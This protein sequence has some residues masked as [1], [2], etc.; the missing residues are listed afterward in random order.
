MPRIPNK[1]LDSTFFLY[2]SKEDAEKGSNY[3]GS[4]FIISMPSEAWGS[5]ITYFYGVTNWH[6]AVSGRCYF[7]R[8]NTCDGYTEIFEYD[9]IDWVFDESGDDLAIILLDLD[10]DKHTIAPIPIDLI[11]KKDVLLSPEE[12]NIGLGDDVFMLGRFVDSDSKK[13]NQ[14]TA[15]FG[16]ISAM[17]SPVYNPAIKRSNESYFLDMHSRS[18]YSGSPVFA[19]RTPGTNLEYILEHLK[20]S[21]QD[22]KFLLLGIHWGQ[23]KETMPIKG[24]ENEH[25]IGMSGMTMAIPSWKILD[26]LQA[27]KLVK[28]RRIADEKWGRIFEEEG[29][30]P[31]RAVPE[32]SVKEDDS[33]QKED[34]HNRGQVPNH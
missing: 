6:V 13:N 2:S 11:Y 28:Q 4:G 25:V 15:R 3:G 33:S 9:S 32:L 34:F 17:P 18:G 14:P 31:G 10:S 21:L 29:R 20:P 1:L 26:L 12:L 8:V 16:H 30:Y 19:Y 5:E 7:V 27:E 22:S 24:C 23:F